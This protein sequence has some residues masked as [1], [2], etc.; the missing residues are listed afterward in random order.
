MLH[1]IIIMFI[2]AVQILYFLRFK[3]IIIINKC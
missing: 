2:M 1:E 3:I